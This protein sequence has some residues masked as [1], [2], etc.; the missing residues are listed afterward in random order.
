MIR[1]SRILVITST[2][3]AAVAESFLA[4]TYTPQLFWTAVAGFALMLIAGR[5]WRP[6]A[7]PVLMAALYLTPS[8][9]LITFNAKGFE[10][11]AIW[12]LPLLGLLLA[13]RG[14]VMTWS[15]PPR[16]RWPLVTWAVIVAITWPIVFLREADFAPWILLNDMRVSNTSIGVPPSLVNLS[17]TY[18]ALGHLLGI[19]FVDALC[20][21]YRDSHVRFRREVLRPLTRRHHV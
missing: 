4:S 2:V 5:L 16:W 19:L 21:W 18:Y 6:V 13:D 7:M 11:D 10:H 9:L 20:R 14:D 8:L 15:L 1:A 17:V 12:I 3:L